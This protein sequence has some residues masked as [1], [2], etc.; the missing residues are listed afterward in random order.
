MNLC[1]DWTKKDTDKPAMKGRYI[2]SVFSD[3]T[4]IGEGSFDLK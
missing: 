3:N 1:L 2:I 4:A